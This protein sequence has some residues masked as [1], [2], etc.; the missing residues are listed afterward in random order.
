MIINCFTFVAFLMSCRYYR[1][2]TVPRGAVDWSVVYIMGSYMSA[3][4]LLNLFFASSTK[5]SCLF[6]STRRKA[7]QFLEILVENLTC[8]GA[9]LPLCSRVPDFKLVLE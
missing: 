1:S 7:A 4:V 5:N 2:L 3:N 8:L 6:K 9:L